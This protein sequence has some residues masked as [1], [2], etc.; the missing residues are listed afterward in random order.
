MDHNSSGQYLLQRET[1]CA[2]GNS[3]QATDGAYEGGLNSPTT[4]GT[5][6]VRYLVKN[7]GSDLTYVQSVVKEAKLTKLARNQT[8]YAATPL[9]N[10]S[11]A[12][13]YSAGANTPLAIMELLA[14]FAPANPPFNKSDT[15]YVN[16]ELK[17]AGICNGTYHPPCGVNLTLAYSQVEASIK[18]YAASS[19]KSLGNGWVYNVPQGTY[20]SNYVDRALVVAV[21]YL[22]LTA[23]KPFIQGAPVKI[24]R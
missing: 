24:P 18:V 11:L 10:A 6:L 1:D 9:T 20:G 14:E 22:E 7:N 4:Y 3:D 16:Q 19:F 21:G 17:A 13:Y 12:G 5:L 2:Q 15:A 8:G 23:I